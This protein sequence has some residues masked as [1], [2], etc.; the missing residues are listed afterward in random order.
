MNCWSGRP[1]FECRLALPARILRG[2]R[3]RVCIARALAPR[4]KLIIADEALSAST[5]R[6]QAQIINLFMDL[7]AERGL[8]YLF[9]S[10]DMAVVEKIAIASRALSRP[11]HG[12]GS[13]RQVFENPSHDYTRPPSLRRSGCRSDGIAKHGADVRAKFQ[14]RSVASA[15]SRPFFHTRKSIRS[16]HRQKRLKKPGSTNRDTIASI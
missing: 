8:A 9:I 11:D 3:Q 12:N 5:C 7:Q 14:I 13:R 10:H 1:T 2:Q 6:I 15:T 16:F 4:S